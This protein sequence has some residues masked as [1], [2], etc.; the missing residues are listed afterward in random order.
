[1]GEKKKHRF[2]HSFAAKTAA[3]AAAVIM[4]CIA[5]LSTVGVVVMFE[6]EV[7]SSSREANKYELYSKT[8]Y[9]DCYNIIRLL[10]ESRFIFSSLRR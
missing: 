6:A 7:Y 2:S 3:F 4:L 10:S 5:A 1:M 8:A 9:N